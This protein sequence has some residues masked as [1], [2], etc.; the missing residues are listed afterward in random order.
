LL[1]NGRVVPNFA[2][3]AFGSGTVLGYRFSVQRIFWI[4]L[5]QISDGS[6][7][8]PIESIT[9][10]GSRGLD[11]SPEALKMAV[12]VFLGVFCG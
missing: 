7:N 3:L 5:D 10:W 1:K 4:Y 12:L 6:D 9:C 8:K 11:G 2:E